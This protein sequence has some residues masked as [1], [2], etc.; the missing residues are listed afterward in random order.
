MHVGSLIASWKHS[1]INN[2]F[3]YTYTNM[4]FTYVYTNEK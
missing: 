3:D 1:R 4:V 2:D